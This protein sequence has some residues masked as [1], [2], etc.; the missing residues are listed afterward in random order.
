MKMKPLSSS[1]NEKND[2]PNPVEISPEQ[3]AAK[4]PTDEVGR[5]KTHMPRLPKDRQ[6]TLTNR[7]HTEK[8]PL[9]A[10]VKKE[11]SYEEK[12]ELI[13]NYANSDSLIRVRTFGVDGSFVNPEGNTFSKPSSSSDAETSLNEPEISTVS[14]K[15]KA[16]DIN[17][18][19]KTATNIKAGRIL[20]SMVEEAV[21]NLDAGFFDSMSKKL[22]SYF[23]RN[24]TN[25]V[26]NVISKP[27][28]PE[29]LIADG[30]SVIVKHLFAGVVITADEREKITSLA[31][32]R[33]DFGLSLCLD[34]RIS[35]DFYKDDSDHEVNVAAIMESTRRNLSQEKPDLKS[36][37]KN[38]YKLARSADE[39]DIKIIMDTLV[40]HQWANYIL[41]PIA[42]RAIGDGRLDLFEA[43]WRQAPDYFFEHWIEITD[44]VLSRSI[45]DP[46]S[47]RYLTNFV[48]NML[49]K[50]GS[51]D[52]ERILE[53]LDIRNRDEYT[54]FKQ[55]ILARQAEVA[56]HAKPGKEIGDS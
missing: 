55:F 1:S 9:S 22:W 28:M 21:E 29:P 14:H 56:G 34:R 27:G 4:N 44:R 10:A 26:L 48:D 18:V 3:G 47:I 46:F 23:G 42:S 7:I 49:A 52:A 33:K 25:M 2:N 5:N 50:G 8:N 24:A 16:E 53:I 39:A 37:Q 38:I 32:K 12:N 20:E 11:N 6:P 51:F 30:I 35:S 40:G 19:Q 41:I 13:E 45:L 43:M 31:V 17:L 36:I 54:E 15:K